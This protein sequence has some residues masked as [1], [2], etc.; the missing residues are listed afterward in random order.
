MG[1]FILGALAHSLMAIPWQVW[2]VV[3]I[4]ALAAI[5]V[6]RYVTDWH[7]VLPLIAAFFT[8]GQVIAWRAHWIEMGKAEVVAQMEG[9]KKTERLIQAC[10]A[11]NTV[12]TYLWDRSQGK[13]L[14]ADGAIQ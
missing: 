10:Y 11:Q 1:D 7:V 4:C 5:F 9:Y 6:I 3:I 13:C 8:I 2:A 12:A 14:R